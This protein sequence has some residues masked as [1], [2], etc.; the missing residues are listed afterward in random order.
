MA[1][2]GYVFQDE[3]DINPFV[4]SIDTHVTG[5]SFHLARKLALQL[6]SYILIGF[7]EDGR[8][9]CRLTATNAN[10]PPTSSDAFDAR[11]AELVAAAANEAGSSMTHFN[12]ALLVDRRG[13]CVHTFRKHFLYELD[14]RWAQ[15]G[16]GFQYV[17]LPDLGRVSLGF[18]SPKIH[19]PSWR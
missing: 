7:P 4:E 2:T 9:Q 16:P 17:D 5:P 10:L 19:S 14:K 8:V 3:A 12:S 6:G 15:E 13:N 1:L 18:R 11:S